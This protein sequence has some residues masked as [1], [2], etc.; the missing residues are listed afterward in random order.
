MEYGTVYRWQPE[1]VV[2]G[3]GE[4]TSLTHSETACEECGA[5]HKGLVRGDLSDRQPPDDEYIHP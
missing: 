3:C 2:V 1:S 4:E 5:E